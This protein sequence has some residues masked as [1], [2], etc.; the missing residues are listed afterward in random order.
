MV[1][2]LTKVGNSIAVVLD[3]SLLEMAGLE[4]DAQIQ[5]TAKDGCIILAPVHPKIADPKTFRKAMKEFVQEND[6]VLRK[7][8]E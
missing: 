8:S 7:L 3:R 4:E 5:L 6:D 1:K 2:R